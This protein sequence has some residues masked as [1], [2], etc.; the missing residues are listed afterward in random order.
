MVERMA[1]FEV[2]PD[3]AAKVGDFKGPNICQVCTTKSNEHQ[4]SNAR[5]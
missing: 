5:N 3:L 2:F 4:P 1:D